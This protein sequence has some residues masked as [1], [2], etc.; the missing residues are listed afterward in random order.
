M[1]QLL[2]AV[3]TVWLHFLTITAVRLFFLTS[4]IFTIWT[5]L[6]TIALSTLCLAG[7]FH[8]LLLRL[9]PYVLSVKLKIDV[10]YCYRHHCCVL[11]G[12]LLLKHCVF[13]M[14]MRASVQTCMIVY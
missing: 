13:G 5:V 1:A 12:D 9:V 14:S 6:P 4:I 3:W 7:L 11:A 8:L 10:E 2:R